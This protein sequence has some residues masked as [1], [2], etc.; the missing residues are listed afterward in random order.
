MKTREMKTVQPPSL[1]GKRERYIQ[2]SILLGLYHRPSYGYEL[3][4]NIQRFGFIV[5]QAPPGMVYRHLHQ[6]EGDGLVSSEWKTEGS[7]PARRMYNLTQDGKE[8]LA[9]WIGY[10]EKQ[11]ENLEEF[12]NQYREVKKR[13]AAED[14]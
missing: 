7:G 8:M 10:M 2:P 4:R 6:L 1:Q 13:D 11:V 14:P 9:L 5:G 12:I 3:I